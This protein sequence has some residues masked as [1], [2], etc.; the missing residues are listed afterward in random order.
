M[1][2]LDKLK[3]LLGGNKDKVKGG[4]DKVSDVVES[5]VGD[6]HAAK[7]DMAADKAKDAIDKLGK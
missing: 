4:I 6:K 1:G 2:L 5:K 3:G 7:V